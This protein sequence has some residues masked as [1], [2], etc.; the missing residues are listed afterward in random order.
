MEPIPHETWKSFERSHKRLRITMMVNSLGE[1]YLGQISRAL[2]VR[3][4]RVLAMMYG[5]APSYSAE[6]GVHT[7]GLVEEIQVKRGRA[8]RIT[9]R[10]RR[11]CRS[12]AAARARAWTV[13]KPAGG[14]SDGP[15]TAMGKEGEGE[16]RAS[17]SFSVRA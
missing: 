14:P 10:G 2:G 8:W 17:W 13:S 7:L 15:P 12:W 11:K 16:S 9:P 1:A 6:L 3:P 4:S 5:A